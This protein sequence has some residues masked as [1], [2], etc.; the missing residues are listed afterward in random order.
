MRKARA[1]LNLDPAAPV[2]RCHCHSAFNGP[3]EAFT[4]AEC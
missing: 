2:I 3:W 4:V 1:A